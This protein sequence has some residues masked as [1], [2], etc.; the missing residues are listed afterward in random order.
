MSRT[1]RRNYRSR[2]WN[3]LIVLTFFLVI[4]LTLLWQLRERD[5]AWAKVLSDNQRCN[6]ILEEFRMVEQHLSRLAR[7]Y[8]THRKAVTFDEHQSTL[9]WCMGKEMRPRDLNPRVTLGKTGLVISHVDLLAQCGVSKPSIQNMKDASKQLCDIADV[10]Q[11]AMRCIKE[12]TL[13]DGPREWRKSEMPDEFAARV[14]Y[15]E[16]YHKASENI[17]DIIDSISKLEEAH[18]ALKAN[19]IRNQKS[20]FEYI[21]LLTQVLAVLVFSLLINSF[22]RRAQADS[23]TIHNQL[24]DREMRIEEMESQRKRLDSERQVAGEIQQNFLPVPPVDKKLSRVFGAMIPAKTIG[25]DFYD[26]YML[27]ETHLVLAIGDVSGKGVPAAMV[28]A[29]SLTLFR[30]GLSMMTLR[31]SYDVVEL[32]QWLNAQMCERNDSNMF[33][34]FFVAIYNT[35]TKTIQYCNAGHNPPIW[36]HRNSRL[37][38]LDGEPGVPLGVMKESTYKQHEILFHFG[39]AIVSYTDGVTE[40]I[41]QNGQLYGQTQLLKM[42]AEKHTLDKNAAYLVDAVI[43]DVNRFAHGALQS[44]DITLL[45]LQE[46]PL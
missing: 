6:L 9:A 34:T 38:M 5:D 43:A 45:V 42:L 39:D 17:V 7:A 24:S 4:Q 19:E 18:A 8:C 21:L 44:D 41:A 33:V 26:F 11:Q 37:E 14:L 20:H 31:G 16:E 30:A 23:D 27:D 2:F 40:A 1:I 36:I 25:G 13:I 28:M 46:P 35:L 29:K 15:D 12:E 22:T 10:E 3:V 32:T